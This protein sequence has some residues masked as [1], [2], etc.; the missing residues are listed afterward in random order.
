MPPPPRI[1][2]PA[3]QPP[4]APD[5]TPAQLRELAVVGVVSKTCP[6]LSDGLNVLIDVLT[7]SA[8]PNG[9]P[10]TEITYKV[11]RQYLLV[12]DNVK[13]QHRQAIG[14]LEFKLQQIDEA[15]E[16]GKLDNTQKMQMTIQKAGMTQ[17]LTQLR[18]L[19]KKFNADDP[20]EDVKIAV[21][22]DGSVEQLD[23]EARDAAEAAWQSKTLEEKQ[24][25]LE[26]AMGSAE[27]VDAAAAAAG[28][29]AAALGALANVRHL[30]ESELHLSA[31][32]PAVG[33]ILDR[34]RDAI[35]AG[36]ATL[37]LVQL[38]PDAGN[39]QPPPGTLKTAEELKPQ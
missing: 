2:G 22:D 5:F 23:T 7:G 19:A 15:L 30:I 17:G 20:A 28:Q 14:D 10:L 9:V 16:K 12:R 8:A 24:A 4:K 25:I 32:W 6:N 37:A 35:K 34:E 36:K 1:V 33:M 26:M 39:A 27:D 18:D 13:K 3:G 11:K 29:R 21:N 31:S 38:Q